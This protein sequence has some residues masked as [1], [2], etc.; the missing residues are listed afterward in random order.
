MADSKKGKSIDIISG[1]PKADPSS[2]PIIVR[3]GPIMR[4]PSIIDQGNSEETMP[5]SE[6]GMISQAKTIKINP[7]SD[8]NETSQE[9]KRELTL[10]PDPRPEPDQPEPETTPDP[11]TISADETT[12]KPEPAQVTETKPEET[13]PKAP[14][15]E[16]PV[17]DMQSD[18]A[19]KRQALKQEEADKEHLKKLDQ[20]VESERY[21]LPIN[22]REK[23]QNRR[24]VII[25]VVIAILLAIVWVDVALDAGLIS[26]S[27][28]LP[29][30]HFFAAT[31]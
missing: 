28:H 16:A 30:T 1:A 15:E 29:H 12:P 5:K 23:R 26:N 9:P 27:L 4:D 10:T 24:V 7:V 21:F 13:T 14:E 6:E 22:M 20:L 2:R 17:T 8:T 19:L 25:G 31:T 11:S 18:A 3:S